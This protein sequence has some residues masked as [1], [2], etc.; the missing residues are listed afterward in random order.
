MNNNTL[1]NVLALGIATTQYQYAI[2]NCQTVVTAVM[3]YDLE[4]ED[5]LLMGTVTSS[6]QS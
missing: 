4:P 3:V 5:S 6:I 1:L 2:G